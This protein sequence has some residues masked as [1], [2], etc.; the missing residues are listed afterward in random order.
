MLL[1]RHNT[2]K[3][4]F[5]TRRLSY[6]RTYTRMNFSIKLSGRRKREA[7]EETETETDIRERGLHAVAAISATLIGRDPFY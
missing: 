1:Y 6:R 7:G 5:G 3:A 4:Y 2:H